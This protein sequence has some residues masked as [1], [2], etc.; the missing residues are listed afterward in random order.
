MSNNSV[1]SGWIG[2]D[3]APCRLWSVD[4]SHYI[5]LHV[6]SVL[7]GK[8]CVG[9]RYTISTNLGLSRAEGENVT[10]NFEAF[11]RE[12]SNVANG[13][14]V[15]ASFVAAPCSFRVFWGKRNDRRQGVVRRLFVEGKL[16][17]YSL[18]YI[19][20]WPRELPVALDRRESDSLVLL[21]SGYVTSCGDPPLLESFVDEL[22]RAYRAAMDAPSSP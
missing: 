2:L 15:E 18:T 19:G 12:L 8:E 4:R 10:A 9:I 1:P 22:R 20:E 16:S 6:D 21:Q 14:L 17:D 11:I 5:E 13:D 3:T 7:E